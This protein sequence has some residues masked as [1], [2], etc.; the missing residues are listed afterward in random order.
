MSS[1]SEASG[2]RAREHT[3]S[4][5]EVEGASRPGTRPFVATAVGQVAVATQVAPTGEPQHTRLAT[6]ELRTGVWTRFGASNVL[7]DAITEETLSTLAESTRT[8][9][10]SQGYAVGWADG[11]RA[12][13]E[14]AR[15]EA[16]AAEQARLAAEEERER[17]HRA[18]VAALELAAARIHD[19]VDGMSARIE[20]QASTLAWDLTC[21]LVGHELRSVTGPDVVRRALK[22]APTETIAKLYLHPDH[23]SDLT[24]ADLAELADHGISVANDPALAWGD[25]LAETADHV[26]DLRVR[27][28]LD[29]VREVLA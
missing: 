13:R 29:R 21:E 2:V 15:L 1:S 20:E 19:A 14:Q 17:E 10:R 22:L 27:T 9:A 23:V 16:Q 12:A 26:I 11:Q 5:E 8:A 25:A 6:P 28:A 4:A 18:A 24:P 7:G 3:A